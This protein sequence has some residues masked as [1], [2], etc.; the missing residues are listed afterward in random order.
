MI[1]DFAFGFY[2]LGIK[3]LEKIA[4]LVEKGFLSGDLNINSARGH[5]QIAIMFDDLEDY[6][7]DLEDFKDADTI[8]KEVSIQLKKGFGS[9]HNPGF[10]L[11]INR[12]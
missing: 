3:D 9:G 12:K 7:D 1:K 6:L 10:N 11:I 4:E 2:D 5:W 8:R